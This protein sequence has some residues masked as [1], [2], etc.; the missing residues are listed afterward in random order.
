LY[1]V[2]LL[3]DDAII[4]DMDK[5]WTS[6]EDKKT[7]VKK[8]SHV[9]RRK[10]NGDSIDEILDDTTLNTTSSRRDFLKI[11]GFSIATA[12]I[13]SACEQPIRKAIPYLIAP[14]D[15]TPGKASYFASTFFDGQDYCSILVKVR[16]GRPIK[17]EGNE[18]SPVTKGGTSARV[19]ASVLGIYDD[20]RYMKPLINK[21]ET[22]WADIDKE[23]ISQLNSLTARAK[24]IVLLTPNHH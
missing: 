5:Y 6:L 16:D 3:I 18:L 2:P 20:A 21:V 4:F 9:N 1:E 23:I 10:G 17:I 13:V 14:D 15:I 7:E 19:Q 12:T 11:F 22:T 24:D 8:V